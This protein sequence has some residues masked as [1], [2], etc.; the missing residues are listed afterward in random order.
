[1]SGIDPQGKTT[2]FDRQ[3]GG[4]AAAAKVEKGR[5]LP[6]IGEGVARAHGELLSQKRRRCRSGEP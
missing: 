2:S 6:V 5:L 1:M 3:H 4:G